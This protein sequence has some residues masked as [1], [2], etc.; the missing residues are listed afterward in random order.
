[1]EGKKYL[2]WCIPPSS[3][4]FKRLFPIVLPSNIPKA[5]EDGIPTQKLDNPEVAF[6]LISMNSTN[7]ALA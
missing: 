5:T 3:P 1:M 2:S 7:T 6:T 4:Q